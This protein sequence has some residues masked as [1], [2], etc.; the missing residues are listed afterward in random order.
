M[1]YFSEWQLIR[2]GI[3]AAF[4]TLQLKL[5]SPKDEM[6]CCV[7]IPQVCFQLGK[8]SVLIHFH[9]QTICTN[10]SRAVSTRSWLWDNFT[11]ACFVMTAASVNR[12]LLYI[13]NK[14]SPHPHPTDEQLRS[15]GE[16]VKLN[17]VNRVASV[18]VSPITHLRRRGRRG[19]IAPTHSW[20]R[21]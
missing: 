4:T 18:K 1:K 3:H 10:R 12:I 11:A 14:G 9:S 7:F 21:H 5:S 8:F 2:A 15:W 13:L 19:G 6:V 16:I 20:P 17:F